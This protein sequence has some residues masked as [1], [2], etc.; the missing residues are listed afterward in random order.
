MLEALLWAEQGGALNGV[1]CGASRQM[2]LP[3]MRFEQSVLIMRLNEKKSARV[4]L[5]VELAMEPQVS[6]CLTRYVVQH[7]GRSLGNSQ[8][9]CPTISVL[10]SH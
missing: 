4:K 1:P 9:L 5:T 6:P 3:A 7:P 2:F 8:L 10:G